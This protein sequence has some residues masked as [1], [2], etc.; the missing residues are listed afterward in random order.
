MDLGQHLERAWTF[1][2]RAV[3]EEDVADVGI[4]SI[5]MPKVADALS[6]WHR[7]DPCAGRLPAWLIDGGEGPAGEQ[8]EPTAQLIEN[9]SAPRL[10]P[11]VGPR[12]MIDS[13]RIQDEVEGLS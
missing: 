5:S 1:L 2:A 6:K 12:K 4:V 8:L 13:G 7:S 11:D 3:A 10:M 9:R